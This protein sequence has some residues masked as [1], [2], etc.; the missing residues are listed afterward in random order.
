MQIMNHSEIELMKED[1]G[2]DAHNAS[3]MASAS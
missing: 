3:S 2:T 1:S